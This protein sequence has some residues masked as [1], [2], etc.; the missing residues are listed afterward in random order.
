MQTSIPFNNCGQYTGSIEAKF[1]APL[2]WEQA[3]EMSPKWFV[4]IEGSRLKLEPFTEPYRSEFKE[5]FGPLAS[6]RAESEKLREIFTNPL[7][8][9]FYNN[10]IPDTSEETQRRLNLDSKRALEGNIFSGY[11]IIDKSTDQTIGRISIGAGELPGQS[12]SGLILEHTYQSDEKKQTQRYGT[13][14]ALLIGALALE[15]I[16]KGW[17]VNGEP[18]NAFSGTTHQNNLRSIQLMTH[19]KLEHK[20]VLEKEEKE[21]LPAGKSLYEIRK[22]NVDE[23][24]QA[25]MEDSSG[26][27]VSYLSASIL[28]Q[29]VSN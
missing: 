9:G 17:R 14:A 23:A 21:Q 22:E 26:L 5:R 20:T 29:P 18:V 24:I 13:E 10:G 12:Q 19:L 3:P 27:K 28:P 7:S 2:D 16:K 25:L 11:N 4:I 1:Y 6:A 15:A 8:L